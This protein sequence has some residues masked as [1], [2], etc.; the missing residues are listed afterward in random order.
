M[1]L[2]RTD[3]TT[4]GRSGATPRPAIAYGNS[5]K[6]NKNATRSHMSPAAAKEVELQKSRK[7]QNSRKICR[8]KM[9]V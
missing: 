4:D 2:F 6:K 8:N 5:G 7:S 9:A 1:E 3:G